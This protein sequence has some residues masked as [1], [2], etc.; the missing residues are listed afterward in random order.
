MKEQEGTRSADGPVHR[1]VIEIPSSDQ[2]LRALLS[3]GERGPS[4][5]TV[6]IAQGFGRHIRHAAALSWI[7]VQHGYSTL[8]FEY[9]GMYDEQEALAPSARLSAV[10]DD[11]DDAVQHLS[12]SGDVYVVAS[13]IAARAA[14]RAESRSP[15]CAGLALVMPTVDVSASLK[16]AA[17]GRDVVSDTFAEHGGAATV[18]IVGMKVPVAF[19]HDLVHTGLDNVEDTERDL[20]SITCPS[21]VVAGE[22]DEWVDRD[23]LE[24][25][26]RAASSELVIIQSMSHRSFSPPAQRLVADT[27]V[28]FIDRVSGCAPRTVRHPTLSETVK[29]V[30]EEAALL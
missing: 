5:G 8:R 11:I 28:E 13:S 3:F 18:S 27:I 26:V 20:A 29:L 17:A 22:S 1:T 14:I 16:R 21:I 7:L 25:A 24:A 19:F 10:V 23:E 12:K 6:V 9:R 30:R 2:P 4:K 15:R